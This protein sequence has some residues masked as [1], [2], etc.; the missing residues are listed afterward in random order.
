MADVLFIFEADV[1]PVE[2]VFEADVQ[3]VDFL[4]GVE[5]IEISGTAGGTIDVY[6]DGVLN[7]SIVSSDLNAEII[8]I[9][10]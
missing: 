6:I 7:Q 9:V 2:F 8:E 1:Q 10:I 4:F 3:P 5:N